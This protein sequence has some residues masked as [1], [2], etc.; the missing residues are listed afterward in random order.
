MVLH[1]VL[2]KDACFHKEGTKFVRKRS[3]QQQTRIEH[4]LW[5]GND[6]LLSCN[7]QPLNTVVMT[8]EIITS[9]HLC[10]CSLMMIIMCSTYLL[11]IVITLFFFVT[12][13]ASLF[14]S[15]PWVSLLDSMRLHECPW[16]P[17]ISV[18]LEFIALFGQYT[19]WLG[20]LSQNFQSIVLL[21]FCPNK[22]GRDNRCE[23][24]ILRFFLLFLVFL[25]KQIADRLRVKERRKNA[26][27]GG[28]SSV[29]CLSVKKLMWYNL[30]LLLLFA[31]T[32]I[33]LLPNIEV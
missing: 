18:L 26:N 11:V 9:F 20:V 33:L 14:F 12:F 5:D 21:C 1:H 19:N 29:Y 31:L 28:T 27:G 22:E 2:P 10:G 32:I 4:M 17:K 8:R 24:N 7:W 16:V 13:L 15:Y 6:V 3:H 30:L 23:R 25:T